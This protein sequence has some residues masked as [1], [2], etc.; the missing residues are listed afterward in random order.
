MANIEDPSKR[1]KRVR[2]STETRV[3]LT[4]FIDLGMFANLPDAVEGVV[5][6][7]SIVTQG[8]E[9]PSLNERTKLI[10][11]LIYQTQRLRLNIAS[12]MKLKV[13]IKR[14]TI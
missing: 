10:K 5:N 2:I 7:H 13:C 9:A 14:N 3:Y 1:P 11:E 4:G 6:F 12:K 8:N